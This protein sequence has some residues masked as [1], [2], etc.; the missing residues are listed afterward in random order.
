[1]KN[2]LIF[3]RSMLASALI[4]GASMMGHAADTATVTITATITAECSVALDEA[5]VNMGST[6]AFKSEGL[7]TKTVK[8]TTNCGGGP[9]K[10]TLTSTGANGKNIVLTHTTQT[11]EEKSTL[12]VALK[13]GDKDAEFASGTYEADVGQN[14]VT[15]NLVFSGVAGQDSNKLDSGVYQGNVTVKV[16]A[17]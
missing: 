9:G 14:S 10:L 2:N 15:T 11:A 5:A 13:V 3:Q 17:I 7:T 8:V 12:N 4:F 16:A 6:S 1:M